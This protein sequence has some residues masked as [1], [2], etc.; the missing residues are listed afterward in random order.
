LDIQACYF[1][2][3]A[4]APSPTNLLILSLKD[5][6]T[7]AAQHVKPDNSIT[8]HGNGSGV[9]GAKLDGVLMLVGKE[10]EGPAAASG[11]EA[12]A[13][14]WKARKGKSC[15]TSSVDMLI[16]IYAPPFLPIAEPISWHCSS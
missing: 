3:P 6:C 14:N 16:G 7:L 13:A 10:A 5:K 8:H 9:V 1:A 11:P 4:P 2:F 15:S 12:G